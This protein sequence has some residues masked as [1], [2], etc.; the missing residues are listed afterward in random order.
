MRVT[1]VFLTY[2]KNKSMSVLDSDFIY[3]IL[4]YKLKWFLVHRSSFIVHRFSN[5]VSRTTDIGQWISN[6]GYRTTKIEIQKKSTN[7]IQN[8]F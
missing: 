7:N 1:K 2:T 4:L 8:S 6:N 5:I 3:A